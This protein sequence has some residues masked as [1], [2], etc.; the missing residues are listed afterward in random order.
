LKKRKFGL[1]MSLILASGT[2]LAACGGGDDKDN[3]SDDK[4][5]KS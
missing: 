4:G 2:L 3:G 1:A 5:K